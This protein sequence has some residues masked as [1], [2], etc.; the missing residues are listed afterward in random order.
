MDINRRKIV[1]TG[2]SL[3]IVTTI[4]GRPLMAS[5]CTPSAFASANLSGRHDFSMCKSN[6]SEYWELNTSSWIIDP[7]VKYSSVFSDFVRY[8]NLTIGEVISLKNDQYF[9]LGRHAVAAYL[10]AVTYGSDFLYTPEQVIDIY[11]FEVSKS[12][13]ELSLFFAKANETFEVLHD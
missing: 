12:V 5:S 7:T 11:Q 13:Q 6:S 10:N 4:Y 8:Q 9:D 1:A 3:P 2:A